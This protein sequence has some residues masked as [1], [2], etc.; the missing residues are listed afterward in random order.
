MDNPTC[1]ASSA[2]DLNIKTSTN[3]KIVLENFRPSNVSFRLPAGE[4]WAASNELGTICFEEMQ[5][6]DFTIR[7]SSIQLRKKMT[8]YFCS[9]EPLAGMRIAVKNPW[10]FGL[11]GNDKMK[12]Q[13]NQYVLFYPGKKGEKAVFEK[14]KEYQS[15]EVFCKPQKLAEELRLCPFIANFLDNKTINQPFIHPKPLWVP[16]KVIE[17]LHELPGK[18]VGN[19]LRTL[20]YYLMEQMNITLDEDLPLMREVLAVRAAREII[21]KDV[22]VHHTIDKIARK[23]ELNEFRLKYVFKKVFGTSI[24]QYLLN[25]RMQKAKFLLENTD[26][27]MKEVAEQTGYRFLTSFITS[28]HK[29]YNYT[30]RMVKRTR[31]TTQIN[32]VITEP[33]TFNSILSATHI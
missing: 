3:E 16:H 22:S 11:S 29:F 24:Y 9:E 13:K 32:P 17:M 21:I 20:F 2:I 6:G 10:R 12:L 18:K 1:T 28:F 19:D 4:T 8:L 23:V 33:F 15:F 30:P 31:R 27:S 7:S 14:D 25:E 26:K 5:T